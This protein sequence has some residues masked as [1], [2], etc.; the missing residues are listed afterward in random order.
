M[1]IVTYEYYSETYLGEPIAVE[2]FPKAEAKAERV[3]IHITHGRAANYAALPAFQQS[4]I[5]DAIC[6]QVEY[7]SIMGT[8]V[9]VDGDTGGN[10]W[11]VGKVHVNGRSSSASA[12]KSGA[13]TLVCA[14]AITALELTGLL[15]PQVPTVGE[16][17]VAPWWGW[18]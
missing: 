5:R 6:A 9:S 10:G 7:Y 17:F 8:D 1:A 18:W 13:S 2:D 3:I 12:G 14:A 4:A 11:T 15:N 16:P